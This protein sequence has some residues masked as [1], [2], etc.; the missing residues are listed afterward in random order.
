MRYLVIHSNCELEFL[1]QRQLNERKQE[2]LAELQVGHIR[3]LEETL[4]VTGKH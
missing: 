1:N 3:I 2:L 4:I